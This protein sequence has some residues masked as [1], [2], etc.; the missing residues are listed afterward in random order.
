MR[1]KTTNLILS[2]LV[3]VLSSTTHGFVP[4]FCNNSPLNHNYDIRSPSLSMFTGIVEE[5]GEVVNLEQRDDMVLWDGSTG[6]GTELT[7]K[8][9]VIMDGAYLG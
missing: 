1:L 9:D 4:P 8:A 3:V 5:M 7:V 6:K 2:I